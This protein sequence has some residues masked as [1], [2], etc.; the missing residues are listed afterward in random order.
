MPLSSMTGFGQAEGSTPSGDFYIEVR[1]V[2]GRFFDIQMRIPRVFANLE[3]QIKKFIS[4]KI[5]RGSV[6]HQGEC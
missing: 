5:T 1:S 4:T 3:A 6:T 2:N